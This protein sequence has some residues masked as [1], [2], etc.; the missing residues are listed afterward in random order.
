VV[1]LI[2]SSALGAGRKNCIAWEKS[3][4]GM[5]VPYWLKAGAKL[6]LFLAKL[7]MFKTL[8]LYVKNFKRFLHVIKSFLFI[9]Y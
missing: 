8:L 9:S 3:S 4:L 7:N 5:R 1:V 2:F 6:P